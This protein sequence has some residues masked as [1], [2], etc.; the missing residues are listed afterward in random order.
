MSS[1]KVMW[2]VSM[3]VLCLLSPGCT[4]GQ[5][6]AVGDTC[7]KKE[8][9]QQG[10]T[11]VC[12]ASSPDGYCTSACT[13]STDCGQGL[14]VSF[15]S[16]G[17]LC[18]SRCAQESDCRN[19]YACATVG[20]CLAAEGFDCDPSSGDGSCLTADMHLGACLRLA[21][22]PGKKGQCT[23]Q[24]SIGTRTC[25]DGAGLPRQCLLMDAT[26]NQDGTTA[27]DKWKG[28]AC[29][30]SY[31]NPDPKR[32]GEECL[33]PVDT[34]QQH[35]IGACVDGTEC[36]LQ[37]ESPAGTGFDLKGDNTCRQLCYLAGGKPLLDRP[38]SA[39]LPPGAVVTG[40]T[41]PGVMTCTD[42]LGLATNPDAS[43]RIG[44]CQ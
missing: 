40:T 36:Y 34:M 35:L 6:G 11:P 26:K 9:C 1:R 19:G 15:G 5:S 14:C 38:N 3:V 13:S 21:K 32:L 33:Y 39:P 31:M 20:A 30:T 27:Q 42:I 23:D 12:F 22:G 29:V 41:C 16:L 37:G 8:D 18:L 25:A 43:R 28:P 4:S 2:S 10:P 7:Q 24:C 17:K 44:F